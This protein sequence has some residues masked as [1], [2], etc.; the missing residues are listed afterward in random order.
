MNLSR[1]YILDPQG[2]TENVIEVPEDSPGLD[3]PTG[4]TVSSTPGP[5][6]PPALTPLTPRQLRLQLLELGITG[7]MVEAAIDAIEDTS[8]RER[9]RIKW[10]YAVQHDRD[11]PLIEMVGA[12]LNLTPAQIDAAWLAAMAL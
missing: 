12:S 11:E 6:R 8:D 9:A 2:F 10:F 5:Y 3:L 7:A 1:I 4:Y